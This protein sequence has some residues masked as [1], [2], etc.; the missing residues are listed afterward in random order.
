MNQKFEMLP[1]EKKKKNLERLTC[2]EDAE[3]YHS[4][5]QS[6]AQNP[7]QLAS[8]RLGA[9]VLCYVQLLASAKECKYAQ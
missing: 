9:L 8:P 7:A 4:R 3:N 2:Q 1:N 5:D 6:D